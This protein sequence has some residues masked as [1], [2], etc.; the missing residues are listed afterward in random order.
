MNPSLRFYVL[1]LVAVTLA[2][3]ATPRKPPTIS[4]DEPVQAQP[5]PE[6]R[7]GFRLSTI[8]TWN[9]DSPVRDTLVTRPPCS[10]SA[11]K[12]GA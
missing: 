11:S 7:N 12:P 4:L 8:V 6:L 9:V 3:C 1:A 10:T 5:L 2:G